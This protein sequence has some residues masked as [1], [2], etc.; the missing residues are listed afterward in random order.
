[1]TASYLATRGR[2][3]GRDR[4]QGALTYLCLQAVCYPDYMPCMR[5]H[6]YSVLFLEIDESRFTREEWRRSLRTR[7]LLCVRWGQA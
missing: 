3:G 6:E 2:E 1:M 5:P 4:H 7:A